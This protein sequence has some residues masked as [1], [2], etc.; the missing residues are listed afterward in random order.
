MGL[1]L[2]DE[3]VKRGCSCEWLI[4]VFGSLKLKCRGVTEETDYGRGS[5]P[6]ICVCQTTLGT[7]MYGAKQ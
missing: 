4:L 5:H 7:W 3:L 6:L 2:L 1:L